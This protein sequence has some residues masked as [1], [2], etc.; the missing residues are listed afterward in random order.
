MTAVDRTAF[1]YQVRL[2]LVGPGPGEKHRVDAE[3]VIE[4]SFVLCDAE[5]GT[6]RLDPGTGSGL[7]P[8]LDLF[9]KTINT[10]EVDDSGALTLGFGDGARLSIDPHPEFESWHLVGRGVDPISVAPGGE[11]DWRP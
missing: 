9:G 8:V 1:D 10:V 4:T 6:H 7:A 2:T 5:G 11:T 3:L